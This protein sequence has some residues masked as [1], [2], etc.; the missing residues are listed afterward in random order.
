MVKYSVYAYNKN[1][2]L[3]VC[4]LDNIDLNIERK[5]WWYSKEKHISTIAL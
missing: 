5:N 3:N 1:K 4:A 2:N